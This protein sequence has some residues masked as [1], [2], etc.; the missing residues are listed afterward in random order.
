[1]MI[2][3]FL[4]VA[5]IAA[6]LGSA[7]RAGEP[8]VVELFTSQGCSSC[9][10][11]DALLAQLT[12][13]ED[14]IALALHVDYWDYIGWEDQFADPAF[15]RRQKGYANAHGARTV[16]T[17][18]MVI[19]GRSAIVGHKPLELAERIM[20]ESDAPSPVDLDVTLDGGAVEV[21]LT[22]REPL[23][24]DVLV[25]LVRYDA[26]ETVAISRGENAGHTY[27]YHNIVTSWETI[28]RWDGREALAVRHEAPGD[29][30]TVVLVQRAGYGPILA[31]AR[32][33]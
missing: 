28:A 19:A 11:A 22:P 21:R 6:T 20:R 29:R 12:E 10:P 31:A 25:Q 16:Y 1:M 5:A 8:V 2:R 13:R 4:A 3:V 27:T 24:G 23:G 9:P 7:L 26:R 30:P 33:R 14:I 18:Q 32:A 15:T 17:P